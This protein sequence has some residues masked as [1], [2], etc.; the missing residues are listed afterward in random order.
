MFVCMCV[1][2]LTTGGTCTCTHVWQFPLK[3]L[4]PRNLPHRETQIPQYL[5]VQIQIEIWIRTEE[6]GFLDLMGFGVVV[7]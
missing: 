7:F 2:E 3:M 5:A 4:H 1:R 6:F